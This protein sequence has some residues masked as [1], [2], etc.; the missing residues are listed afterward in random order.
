MD[1]QFSVIVPAYNAEKTIGRCLNRLINTK[2]NDFEIIII[3]DGSGDNTE[4]ICRDIAASDDRVKYYKK[5]N[6]GVSSARNAGL[7]HAAGK[8]IC[9]VDSDDFVAR[10]YFEQ[11]SSAIY[12]NCDLLIYGR[13]VY[14]GQI[15]TLD[16]CKSRLIFSPDEITSFLC[17]ELRKQ[18][19]N[20][21]CNK[22]F[23]RDL[24]E[25]YSIS[26]PEQLH[27]GEDK[28]FVLR[29]ITAVHNVKCIDAFLYISS[30]ENKN[31]LSRK[32]R[33]DLC[34]SVILEHELM[35]SAI[36]R[37]DLPIMYKNQYLSALGFSY[38]RS[39]YTVIGEIGRLPLTE[40]EK[41]ALDKAICRK[42]KLHGEKYHFDLKSWCIALPVKLEKVVFI[43]FLVKCCSRKEKVEW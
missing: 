14:N 4:N 33:K 17:T 23:R 43:S 13:K 19:L 18:K 24:I 37:S 6:G 31:S 32:V 8:Y 21:V 27:I 3:D 15:Y 16:K 1:I 30:T 10:D 22:V 41:K 26:F 40:P 11:I 2:R 34:E 35:I 36:E 28:V 39:A 5:Q 12:E 7:K 38:Y 9:F 29:Y 20:F 25:K 42:Y